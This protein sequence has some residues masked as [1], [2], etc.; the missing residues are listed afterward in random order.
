[1]AALLRLRKTDGDRKKKR[2]KKR[3]AK[4]VEA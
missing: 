1:L 2:S 3:K 4:D